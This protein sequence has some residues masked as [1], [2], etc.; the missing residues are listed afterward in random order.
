[1]ES[2]VICNKVHCS[3]E[4]VFRRS[5]VVNHSLLFTTVSYIDNTIP[6]AHDQSEI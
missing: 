3:L 5:P 1:M 4:D 2:C 6:I